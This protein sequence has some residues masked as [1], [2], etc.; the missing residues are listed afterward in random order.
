M[1]VGCTGAVRPGRFAFGACDFGGGGGGGV[2][3]FISSG[4]GDDWKVTSIS[5]SSVALST[6]C[7]ARK[8]RPAPTT[9]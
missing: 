4:S 2:S 6:V 3:F 7:R 8:R 1:T 9:P 5:G